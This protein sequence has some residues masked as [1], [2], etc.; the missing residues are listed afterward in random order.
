MILHVAHSFAD[1]LAA[2]H[3]Q[4]DR[5]TFIRAATDGRTD[6][7]RI[8]DSESAPS[9]ATI[10]E[11]GRAIE[12]QLD[13]VEPGSAEA[14]SLFAEFERVRDEYMAA[15]RARHAADPDGSR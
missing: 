3:P 7:Q 6:I 13:E 2:T 9:L 11:R 14:R 4:F 15:F 12:R 1:E 10:L 5:V 8:E